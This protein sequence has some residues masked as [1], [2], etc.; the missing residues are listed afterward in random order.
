MLRG[1]SRAV[2]REL[3]GTHTYE[4]VLM[5]QAAAGMALGRSTLSSWLPNNHCLF[6]ATAG[7]LQGSPKGLTLHVS[8]VLKDFCPGL[9]IGQQPS[10]WDVFWG[11]TPLQSSNT[12]PVRPAAQQALWVLRWRKVIASEAL[13][14]FSLFHSCTDRSSDSPLH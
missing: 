14:N 5:L 7:C 2:P 1:P 4:K 10:I 13:L 8:R 11:G 6:T 9:K 3:K 12:T